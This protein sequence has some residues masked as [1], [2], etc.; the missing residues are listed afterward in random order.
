MVEVNVYSWEDVERDS[1]AEALESAEPEARN[2]GFV[3]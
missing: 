2:G 1:E 3:S